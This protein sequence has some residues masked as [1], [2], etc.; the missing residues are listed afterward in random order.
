MAGL[1]RPMGIV[2]DEITYINLQQDF[3]ARVAK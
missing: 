3:A 2:A 1:D